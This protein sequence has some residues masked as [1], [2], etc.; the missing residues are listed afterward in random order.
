V[1]DNSWSETTHLYHHY[2]SSPNFAAIS[3]SGVDSYRPGECV[4][5]D[6]HSAFYSTSVG[7]NGSDD[8]W[9]GAGS[10]EV[11]SNYAMA[12]VCCYA[13]SDCSASNNNPGAD[14]T[15][16]FWAS[17]NGEYSFPST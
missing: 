6:A 1:T 10:N 17:N 13:T 8:V 12:D 5:I 4:A 11:E 16:G 15:T 7:I 9:N 14:D 3:C 2:A